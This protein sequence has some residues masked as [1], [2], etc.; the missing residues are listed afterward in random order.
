MPKLIHI[1]VRVTESEH[2]AIKVKTAKE[3]TTTQAILKEA[4][5]TYLGKKNTV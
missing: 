2:K 3:G 1:K 4:V 5:D